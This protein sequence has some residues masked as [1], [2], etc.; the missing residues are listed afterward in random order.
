MPIAWL[1]NVASGIKL[2]VTRHLVHAISRLELTPSAVV[3]ASAFERWLRDAGAILPRHK[4]RDFLQA[5]AHRKTPFELVY[6]AQT[7]WSDIHRMAGLRR[8]LG[9]F[10][11]EFPRITEGR[12][13]VRHEVE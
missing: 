8:S 9:S 13:A 5:V 12:I 11:L 2:S 10:W 4:T 3:D 6:E 1:R 7:G